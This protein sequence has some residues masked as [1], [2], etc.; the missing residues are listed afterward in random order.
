MRSGLPIPFCCLEGGGGGPGAGVGRSMDG[1]VGG[2]RCVCST[3]GQ[4]GWRGGLR[5]RF[6]GKC[7]NSGAG[8]GGGLG[9][10]H[11]PDKQST[12]QLRAGLGGHADLSSTSTLPLA[13]LG[14]SGNSFPSAG[15]QFTHQW[16]RTSLSHLPEGIH[17]QKSPQVLGTVLGMEQVLG[18]AAFGLLGADR[19]TGRGVT[20]NDQCRRWDIPQ[21]GM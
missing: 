14:T 11:L 9:E 20:R 18:T 19:A 16:M 21:D 2:P 17:R 7:D 5:R 1:G 10:G 6:W 8:T 12:Q 3:E 4:G 15:P 13:C